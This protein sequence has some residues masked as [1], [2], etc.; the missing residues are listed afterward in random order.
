VPR[1]ASIEVVRGSHL[2]NVTYRS[3]A[4]RDPDH[5]AKARAEQKNHPQGVPMIGVDAFEEWNYFSG[6]RDNSAPLVP[7]IE[8]HRDSYDI[9]GWDYEPG[10]VLVFYAHILQSARGDI[11]TPTGRRAHA[12]LWAGE[13]LRYLHRPG[14]VI[15]DPPDLYAHTPQTG[16]L[17]SEFQDVFPLAWGGI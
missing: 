16:Q 7:D 3:L 17:L 12:F 15:P 2:W 10:D 1:K 11:E 4:G 14:Q 6:V 5:D 8:A 9:V 13:D